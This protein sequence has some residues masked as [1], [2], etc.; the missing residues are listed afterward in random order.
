MMHEASH[1]N[2][3]PEALD[4]AG[5][6]G[7]REKSY[8]SKPTNTVTQTGSLFPFPSNLTYIYTAFAT[9]ASSGPKIIIK[10]RGTKPITNAETPVSKVAASD[11]DM[12]D[13]DIEAADDDSA[14]AASTSQHT[15]DTP[16]PDDASGAAASE[17]GDDREG[18]GPE[19]G[20]E[21]ANITD[22]QR[23]RGRGRGRPRG[24]GMGSGTPRARGRPRGSRGRGRGRG[25]GIT[26]RLPGRTN[27]D[28][29]VDADGAEG[30]EGAGTPG[31]AGMDEDASLS[32]GKP[33]RKVGARVYIIE[34]DELAA[35][36]DPKGNT[37][38]DSQGNLLEGACRSQD[39]HTQ[40]IDPSARPSVQGSDVHFADQTPRT[41]VHACHRRGA[42]LWLP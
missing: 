10:P 42:N 18:E 13:V 23:P 36:E 9:M 26:I 25:R 6:I 39:I 27:E 38:I 16:T 37:K 8:R 30:E 31:A 41:H 32:G 3:T 19:E 29:T 40:L 24:S 7:K 14:P 21:R 2:A 35:D 1:D 33:F 12:L 17:G 34:G 22:G 15:L 20:A 11:T 28:G 5:E 4:N